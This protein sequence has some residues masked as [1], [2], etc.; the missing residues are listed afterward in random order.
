MK[1]SQMT[2]PHYEDNGTVTTCT[3]AFDP[4]RVKDFVRTGSKK[5]FLTDFSKI[6]NLSKKLVGNGSATCSEDDEFSIR[7]GHKIALQRAKI[8]LIAKVRCLYREEL[9]AIGTQAE[10]M[11]DIMDFLQDEQE[12][13]REIIKDAN[14]N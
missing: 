12:K 4:K 7:A 13:C 9:K 11:N 6:K 2:K 10:T 3:I 14:I 1:I 8:D 5:C